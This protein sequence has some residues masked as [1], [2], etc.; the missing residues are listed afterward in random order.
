[1]HIIKTT[2]HKD[3]FKLYL[4]EKWIIPRSNDN[5]SSVNPAAIENYL[6][7]ECYTSVVTRC[8][9]IMTVVELNRC[10][11]FVSIH[12]NLTVDNAAKKCSNLYCSYATMNAENDKSIS[13]DSVQSTRVLILTISWLEIEK[14]DSCCLLKYCKFSSSRWSK[15]T[16]LLISLN[17]ILH[18]S[19]SSFV[20][21]ISKMKQEYS[22]C[23]HLFKLW[24][25]H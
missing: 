5:L 4:L 1:M 3:K 8:N 22:K 7:I 11:T 20:Q 9:I 18:F 15:T 12:L 21:C 17:D 19:R 10:L 13:F 25:F 23:W 2:F 14:S 16:S 24:S 6:L